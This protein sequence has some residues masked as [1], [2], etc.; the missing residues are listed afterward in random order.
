MV[1]R[2]VRGLTAWAGD[3][4][5][6]GPFRRTWWRSPLRGPWLTAVLG[7]V[8]LVGIP[9][10]IVTGLVSYLAYEPELPGNDKTPG[11]G[12]L[13]FYLAGWTTEPRWLYRLTQGVH[14]LLGL[15]LVPVVLAKLW[16]VLPRLFVWPPVRSP[17]QLVERLTLL[18]LVG[19]ILFEIVTGVTNIQNWYVWGFSFYTAHLYGGWVMIGAFAAHVAVKL[20]VMLRTLRARPLRAELRTDLAHTE[21][22]PP[23][24]DGLAPVAPGPPTISRRGALAVVGGGSLLVLATSVGQSIDPLRWTA[25]MAPRGRTGDGGPNDFP[26]NK[27]AEYR[28]ITADQVAAGVWRLELVD[29]DQRVELSRDELLAMEQHTYELPISCVEGW[30]TSQTWTGVRLRD[31]ARLVGVP[32][33]GPA[34]VTS[35]QQG[36][37]FGAASFSAD[38][39][40]NPAS[41]LALRVNGADLSLDHGF[42]ARVIV[43]AAPGVYCTKW[44]GQVDFRLG[45]SA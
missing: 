17:A 1:R 11:K 7:S 41:L 27:T 15:A 9:V 33:P 36:G 10:V 43:P 23:D 21:P 44:V 12:L 30:S 6:P 42:P 38:Q 25:L 3:H 2:T 8:L 19:G 26:V 29:G 37:A 39:V 35:L 16:S 5:P 20:P 13:G 18:L 22:E 24:E 40:L 45:A 28:G 4:P 31:L 32:D 34:R 14:V